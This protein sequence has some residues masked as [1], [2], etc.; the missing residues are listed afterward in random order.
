MTAQER[1]DASEKK[2]CD[3][4]RVEGNSERRVTSKTSGVEC[5]WT[6]QDLLD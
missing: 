4:L 3:E 5:K 1:K 6:Q 2:T